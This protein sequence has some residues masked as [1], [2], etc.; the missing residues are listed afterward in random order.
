MIALGSTKGCLHSSEFCL[1]RMCL[2]PMLLLATSK[3]FSKV[4]LI[5]SG[6]SF[7]EK[8]YEPRDYH[9]PFCVDIFDL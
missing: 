2:A 5:H 3:L 4:Y 8:Y 1:L 7:E 6:G 9:E